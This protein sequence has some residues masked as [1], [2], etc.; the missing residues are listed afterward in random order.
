MQIFLSFSPL[1]ATS[2]HLRTN[3]RS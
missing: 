1:F 3:A 2:F